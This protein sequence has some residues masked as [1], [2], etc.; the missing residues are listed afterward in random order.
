MA[1]AV[2]TASD[3]SRQALVEAAFDRSSIVDFDVCY[4][5]IAD[6]HGG[7]VAAI[8][9]SLRWEHADLGSIDP[10]ELLP[11]AEQRGQMVTLGSW[12]IEKACMQT[13]KW[14]ATRDGRPMRTC[15]GVS[16]SQITDP[17]LLEH[18]LSALALGGAS[19]Q[20]L[21]LALAHDALQASSPELLEH[22]ADARITLILDHRAADPPSP[23]DVAN[24]PVS[25][26][27]V[28]HAFAASDPAAVLPRSAELGRSLELP[29][30]VQGVETR[31][32]L[33]AVLGA[34]SRSR[35]GDCS[36]VRRVRPRSRSSSAASGRSRRCW[37]RPRQARRVARRQPRARDRARGTRGALM[38]YSAGA[39][40]ADGA[41]T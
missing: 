38:F 29:L 5:P 23:A 13:A 34:A 2:A 28:D 36:R 26:L 3:A 30:V 16:R 11:V 31:E 21:A 27:R 39:V 37:R 35:R 41:R 12:A 40:S 1:G 4:Q 24:L 7:S 25:M 32:H 14:P 33:R 18:L 19:G 15:V 6:L 8:E 22:L 10:Q 9:A 20:Q 17:H